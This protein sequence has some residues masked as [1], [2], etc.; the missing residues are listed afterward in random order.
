MEH[1][2]RYGGNGGVT[3]RNKHLML[4]VI[5]EVQCEDFS[6]R[7]VNMYN[8][9]SNFNYGAEDTFLAHELYR[10]R[11]LYEPIMPTFS[12]HQQFSTESIY[13]PDS[14]F[15]YDHWKYLHPINAIE[16]LGSVFALYDKMAEKELHMELFGLGQ[17]S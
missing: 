6:C 4:S 12:Q 16:L 15:L 17:P 11:A 9:W 1:W 13:Y 2:C 3:Y 5:E 8:K 14:L 10:H 7:I